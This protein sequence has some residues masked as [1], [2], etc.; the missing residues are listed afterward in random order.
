MKKFVVT[1]EVDR[2]GLESLGGE[3]V[4]LL[5][6]NYFYAGILEGVNDDF[7]KLKDPRLVYDT[8]TWTA[9]SWKDAQP[10]G[11]EFLYVRIPFIE[12]YCKG[13]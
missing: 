12:S 1:T 6:A 10:M 13:K 7:V 3:Q 9:A 5:C 4:L 11:V 2:E 8:G